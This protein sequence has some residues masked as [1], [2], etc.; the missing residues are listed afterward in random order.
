MKTLIY[1]PTGVHGFGRYRTAHVSAL[2]LT[3]AAAMA[4]V[5]RLDSEGIYVAAR[6]RRGTTVELIP[7]RPMTTRDEVRAL[8]AFRA[9]TDSPLAWHEAVTS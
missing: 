6:I 4:I 5:D 2:P 8:A 1:P 7:I 9:E 3:P